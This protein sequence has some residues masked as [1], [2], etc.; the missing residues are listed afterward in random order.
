M[1]TDMSKNNKAKHSHAKGHDRMANVIIHNNTKTARETA[2]S[3][4]THHASRKTE[5]KHPAKIGEKAHE[6]KSWW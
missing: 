2:A 6:K 3:K 1:A 4:H 5:V